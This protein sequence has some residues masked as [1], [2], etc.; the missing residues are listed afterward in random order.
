VQFNLYIELAPDVL[1][2][3]DRLLDILAGQN[4]VGIA[5][6]FG[7]AQ[8][9]KE[10]SMGTLTCT[11]VKKSK[12]KRAAGPGVKADPQNYVLQD[13][14]DGSF[15]IHGADAAGA[16]VDISGVATLT[17][18]PTSDTPTILTVDPPVGMTDACHGLM[19]GTATVTVTATWNDGSIGP[20]TITFTATVNAGP[21]TGL[22]VDFG[23]P[24]IRV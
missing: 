14:E 19:P 22:T 24:T 9:R 2:R 11:L 21:A 1:K 5:P 18:V 16:V 3:V 7:P 23:T 13:N 20:F 15:T 12:A 17:P 6:T 4:I 8:P 10:K